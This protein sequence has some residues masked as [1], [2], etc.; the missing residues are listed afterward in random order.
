MLDDSS[1]KPK[2]NHN[3]LIESRIKKIWEKENTKDK[4][5]DNI[6][7]KSDL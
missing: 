1:F 3:L 2:L 6:E 7:K 5:E 4:Q